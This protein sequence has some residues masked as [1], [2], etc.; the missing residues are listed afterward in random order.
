MKL[1]MR[2]T[3]FQFFLEKML[4]KEKKMPHKFILFLELIL[5]SLYADFSKIAFHFL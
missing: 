4:I 2:I 5:E 3:H 1:E